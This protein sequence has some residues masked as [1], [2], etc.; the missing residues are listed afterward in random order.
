LKSTSGKQNLCGGGGG[1]GGGSAS[2][3]ERTGSELADIKTIPG[4]N[5]GR[6]ELH[7]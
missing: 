4:K 7:A 6:A 5:G 3:S 1:S 2:D